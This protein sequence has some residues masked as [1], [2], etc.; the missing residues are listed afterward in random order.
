[1]AVVGGDGQ[2][3]AQGK[4]WL[5]RIR[6]GSRIIYSSSSDPFRVSMRLEISC[7]K[8]TRAL[9]SSRT[10]RAHTL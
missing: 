5:D 6:I 10:Q 8:L 9:Y 7:D 2:R 4:R 3:I 1:M